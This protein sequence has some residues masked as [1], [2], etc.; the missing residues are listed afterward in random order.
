MLVINDL[1]GLLEL[2]QAGVVEIHPWG[3]R[4][5]RLEQPD[6]LIFDLDPGEGVRWGDMIK[7]ALHMR[8]LLRRIG[9]ASFVKTTGGKGLHVVVPVEPSLDWDEAKTFT[10]SVAEEMARESPDRY[11]A[12]MS[13]RVRRGRIFVDYL[14]NGRGAT[15]VAAYSTRALPRASV[16]TPL[17]WD[18]LSE[19]LR[20]DH[21]TL[22][23]IRHRLEFLKDDPWVDFFKVRQRIPQARG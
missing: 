6:R 1:K 14:R 19:N 22:S 13:K 9:L 7:A 18:E 8:D 12:V 15:A 21:F 20:S 16:S 3:S 23:N 11:V 2:V 5:E 4:Y 10:A 17:S